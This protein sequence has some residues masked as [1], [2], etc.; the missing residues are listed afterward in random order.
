MDMK[1]PFSTKEPT[2]VWSPHPLMPEK[3]REHVYAP[4]QPN[5]SIHQFLDRTGL[6]QRMGRQHFVLTINGR[7]VPRELWS[8]CY[9]KPGTIMNLYAVVRGG[10]EGSKNPIATILTIGLTFVAPWAAVNIFGMTAGS[11]GAGLVAAGI[12]AVGGLAINAIFPPPRPE[13]R[14][15]QGDSASPTYSLAGGSNRMRR[16]EPM[17][18]VV[19]Q[20][21]IFPDF[22]AQPFNEFRGEDQH[23]MYVFAYGYGDLVLSDH[24]IGDTPIDSYAGV[25]L[26]ESDTDGELTL[27]PGNVDTVEGGA[28]T[29]AVGFV[30]RT[31]SLNTRSIA[32]EIAGSLFRLG[33]NGLEFRE[34][35]LEVEYAVAGSGVWQPLQLA[36]DIAPTL[37]IPPNAFPNRTVFLAIQEYNSNINSPLPA[38]QIRFRNGSRKPLRRTIKVWVAEGQYDV[39][40]RRVTADETDDR[41]VSD[42]VWTQLRSYQPDTADYNGQKR[43]GL[44][45]KASGQLAGTL[46][47]FSSIASARTQ[48]WNGSTW[49][50]QETSNPAWWFLDCARGKFV[51]GKRVW[52][53]GL[54]DSRIDIE[55]I[56]AFGQWCT[57]EGLEI[58]AVFDTQRSVFETLSAIALMGR[59]TLS[60]GTGKL[61]VIWDAPAL[62]VTAVYGMHNILPGTFEVEYATEELADVIEGEF[63]NPELGW[64]QDFVRVTVPGAT[65]TVKVRRI[66]LFG[67]TSRT[68]AAQD[69]NLYAAQNAYRN[70][71]YKWRCDWEAMPSSRGEVVQLTHDLAALDYSGRFVEGGDTTNLKLAR[72]VPLFT[73]GSFILI[74]RPTGE[75][76][77]HSVTAGSGETDT[78]VLTTPLGFDPWTDPD[79]PPYDYV[80]QYGST[81][82][83]GKKVKLEKF[84]PVSEKV[85]EL[86]AIDELPVFYTAKNNPYTYIPPNVLFNT[87]QVGDL[88]LTED[89]IQVAN[90]YMVKVAITWKSEGDYE[91]AEVR[92]GY[93]GNSPELV[94]RDVR[95]NSFEVTVSDG[96]EVEVEIT[97]FGKL[98]RLGKTSKVSTT[99][100]IDFAGIKEPSQVSGFI[101]TIFSTGIRLNWDQVLDVDRDQYEIWLGGTFGSGDQVFLGKSLEHI[102]PPKTAGSYNYHIKA[103]DVAGQ[104]SAL[105][106]SVTATVNVIGAPT[107]SISVEETDAILTWTPPALQFAADTYEVR[108]GVSFV[109][110]ISLGKSKTTTFKTPIDWTGSRTFWVAVTDVAGQTGTAGSAALDVQSASAPTFNA[111]TIAGENVVLSWNEPSTG[112]LPVRE[113]EIRHG[114]SF[115]GGTLVTRIKGT[116]FTLKANWGGNRTFWIAAVDSGNNIGAAGSTSVNITVPIATSI[117]S[118][119]IDNNVMLQWTDS[120]QTLP[121]R[122]YEVRRG[123]LFASAEVIGTVLARFS[124]IFEPAAGTYK[125]WIAPVDSAGNFGVESS[126]SVVV[127]QPPDYVLFDAAASQLDSVTQTNWLRQQGNHYVVNLNGSTQH[128]EVDSIP[129]LDSGITALTFEAW[130]IPSVMNQSG[131]VIE[132]TIGGAA[133]TCALLFLEGDQVKMRVDTSTGEF[134]AVASLAA[135][136]DGEPILVQGRWESGN[137]RIAINGTNVQSIATTGT[138]DQGAGALYVGRLG[139]AGFFFTGG[140]G[141]SRVYKR[142]LSDT[143]LLEHYRGMYKNEANLIASWSF[144]VGS[145]ATVRDDTEFSYNLELIS[146]PDWVPTALDGRFDP[147]LGAAK[148]YYPHLVNESISE[149]ATRTGD[150]TP[151]DAVAGGHEGPLYPAPNN[152]QYI[153]V[154]DLGA[155]LA[156]SKINVVLTDEALLGTVTVTPTISVKEN[157]GDPWTDFAG[158]SSTFATN[159]RYVKIT[160]DMTSAGGSHVRVASQ[161]NTRL[162]VKLVND[163][164]TVTCNAADSGGT[165][166]NFNI[167][168]IDVSSITVTPKGTTSITAVYD[169]VDAPNPTGFKVLLFNPATGARVSGDASWNVKGV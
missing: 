23:A 134:T 22:G 104:K 39:R 56:K 95:G 103:V 86:H 3:D 72:K 120:T 28:L 162:D 96:T 108:W 70:R 69:T 117:S 157:A 88:V 118:Q 154:F 8:K 169:F 121:I 145:G 143:E 161:L 91:F 129:D 21:K 44:D 6:L 165:Q 32:I 166:V 4:I 105:H 84:K 123:E 113:Y 168:F 18:Y 37:V 61:G 144:D 34:V 97:G 26:E 156:S 62:P 15:M 42:I 2:L 75:T 7:Y 114:A 66:Q 141:P 128:G 19:G 83:P 52:G 59:A 107:V 45:I 68:L 106:T 76:S 82:T 98:G 136:A 16:Y 51:D 81:A 155:V 99:K 164:G 27:F 101:A 53:A 93:G 77:V 36:S 100:V 94:G 148:V 67:R 167:A 122:H 64:L 80:W 153:E 48:V 152:A 90:G 146:D 13:L 151:A 12:T 116:T 127:N 115:G 33:D 133:S 109:A 71:R 138:L 63:V 29:A 79:H 54:P 89:G 65:E 137:V 149:Y 24:R 163:G 159:F 139:G 38:G 43:I 132:K 17:P 92:V 58:N 131:G 49:V 124:T 73:L 142:H 14:N 40:V 5:E 140:I 11:L 30:T 31:T 9:P 112:T 78:L 87:V 102:E 1:P 46:Q 160:L 74:R 35:V 41:V 110:G 57:D 125:Y 158:V 135:F 55:G 111:S 47:Q 130:I 10:G 126:T 119:V 25:T 150:A 60:W 50:Q 20:H 147:T 85:V